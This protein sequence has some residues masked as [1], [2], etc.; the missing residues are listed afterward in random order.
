MTT[1]EN[2]NVAYA[3]PQG[4]MSRAFNFASDQTGFVGVIHDIQPQ[5]LTV[6][7]CTHRQFLCFLKT[8]MFELRCQLKIMQRTVGTLP[9][10]PKGVTVKPNIKSARITVN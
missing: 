4:E 7:Q 10:R 9:L 5:R 8:L 2:L 6:T 1:N 3:N